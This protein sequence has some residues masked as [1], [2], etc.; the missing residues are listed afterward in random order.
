M[1]DG[2]VKLPLI[3]INSN[4]LN[5]KHGNLGNTTTSQHLVAIHNVIIA[6]VGHWSSHNNNNSWTCCLL[7]HHH[8][9]DPI[10]R[11]RSIYLSRPKACSI[12]TGSRRTCRPVASR[13]NNEMFSFCVQISGQALLP[14]TLNEN[15]GHWTNILLVSVPL[16]KSVKRG[17]AYTTKT[18]IG[19]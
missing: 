7:L 16:E 13:A 4:L 1:N 12:I 10:F 18:L 11:K 2:G 3:R 5:P 8:H 15:T 14:W 19:I 17:S 6:F 9:I